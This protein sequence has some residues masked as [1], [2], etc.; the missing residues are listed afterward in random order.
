M[1]VHVGC[2]IL[3]LFECTTNTQCSCR[4]IGKSV[5]VFLGW[6]MIW[7]NGRLGH[8]GC[9]PFFKFA[10][11]VLVVRDDIHARVWVYGVLVCAMEM[12]A[13]MILSFNHASLSFVSGVLSVFM[14][15]W[16]MVIPS[17]FVICGLSVVSALE[18][19]WFGC[20]D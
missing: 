18:R 20:G 3:L 9:F 6:L 8:V 2:F 19:I 13:S 1:Y 5:C 16:L 10:S 11:M 4:W 17:M 7:R 12:Y 14:S 15:C